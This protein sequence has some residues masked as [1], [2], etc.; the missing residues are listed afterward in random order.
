MRSMI[1][2]FID[3]NLS[4]IS[5]DMSNNVINGHARKDISN[6]SLEIYSSSNLVLNSVLVIHL[7]LK[8]SIKNIMVA[9]HGISR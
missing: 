3:W 5:T 6:N 2:S 8:L 7:N 9:M 1:F 4:C